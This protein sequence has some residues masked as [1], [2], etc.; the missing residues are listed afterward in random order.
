MLFTMPRW[1]IMI[2]K[3]HHTFNFPIGF[4]ASFTDW[5]III[6]TWSSFR[7]PLESFPPWFWWPGWTLDAHFCQRCWWI[8]FHNRSLLVFVCLLQALLPPSLLHYHH[9]FGLHFYEVV[10]PETW[11]PK[12]CYP[13]AP[14]RQ[15]LRK[16]TQT[17]SVMMDTFPAMAAGAQVFMCVVKCCN[18][19]AEIKQKE[20]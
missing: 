16:I 18:T 10:S 2:N 6:F 9:W 1:F 8:L 14:K 11:Q 3:Q 19:T 5:H 12:K 13:I 7:D 15:Y 17:L 4:N 20:F